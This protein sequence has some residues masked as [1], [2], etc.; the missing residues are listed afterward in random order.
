MLGLAGLGRESTR[1]TPARAMLGFV[2][3]AWASHRIADFGAVYA[4]SKRKR[5]KV[6]WVALH[7]SYSSPRPAT[8]VVS[9]DS[10][11][12]RAQVKIGLLI[13]QFPENRVA[14]PIIGCVTAKSQG[15]LYKSKKGTTS[16]QEWSAPSRWKVVPVTMAGLVNYPIENSI[17]QKRKKH[18]QS[19]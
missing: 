9:R 19:T 10:G 17:L 14:I 3:L 13:P 15:L 16:R 2:G 6:G 7:P 5:E 18:I 11:L 12:S 4:R 8:P 1:L